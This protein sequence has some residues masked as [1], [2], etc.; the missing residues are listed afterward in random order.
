LLLASWGLRCHKGQG[1]AVP[2]TGTQRLGFSLPVWRGLMD[3]FEGGC[4]RR[5][6]W[7]SFGSG[8]VSRQRIARTTHDTRTP[9]T[10]LDL[11][12]SIVQDKPSTSTA[13]RDSI[14]I[15]TPMLMSIVCNLSDSL[16]SP[17]SLL[18]PSQMR[19]A[20][21][22]TTVKQASP[23]LDALDALDPL[24]HEAQLRRRWHD[25]SPPKKCWTRAAGRPT[26][27]IT[28]GFLGLCPS[29]SA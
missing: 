12:K 25:D 11:N 22:A 24:D 23:N 27:P 4:G 21:R 29:G 28:C 20:L 5:G 18:L 2:R 13:S 8:Q 7:F 19:I 3:G 6:A 26:Q 16:V 15:T 1:K 14:S 10:L 9:P 17:S